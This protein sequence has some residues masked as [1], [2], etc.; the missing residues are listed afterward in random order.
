MTPRALTRLN[1]YLLI[2]CLFALVQNQLLCR[3]HDESAFPSFPSTG[4]K[5][6]RTWLEASVRRMHHIIYKIFFSFF[7]CQQRKKLLFGFL[8]YDRKK[9][10]LK[11]F[12]VKQMK[13]VSFTIN[14]KIES[15]VKFVI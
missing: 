6:E 9:F 4:I 12:Y 14:N 2:F 10:L 15:V 13:N 8:K 7:C 3:A 1:S 5:E 11:N